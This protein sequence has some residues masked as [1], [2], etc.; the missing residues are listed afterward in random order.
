MYGVPSQDRA[1]GIEGFKRYNRAEISALVEVQQELANDGVDDLANKPLVRLS[2]T[3][4]YRAQHTTENMS[5][6]H[7]LN[8]QRVS[9]FCRILV[10]QA[11]AFLGRHA[12]D[13]RNAQ[14]TS[15]DRARSY[16]KRRPIT[17]VDHVL[18]D[19]AEAVRFQVQRVDGAK[20]AT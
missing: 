12:S 3:P 2:R 4:G 14:V 5:R 19:G 18:T 20:V 6:D 13:G 15:I 11:G 8:F 1:L 7:S 16:V 17:H 10:S 9:S